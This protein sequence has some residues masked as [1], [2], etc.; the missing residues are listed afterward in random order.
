MGQATDM[1]IVNKQLKIF[2]HVNET[3]G[4]LIAQGLNVTIN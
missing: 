4:Q 2:Q 3:L 1:S